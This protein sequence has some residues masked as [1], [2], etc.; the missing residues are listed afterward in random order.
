MS[1]EPAPEHAPLS[2]ITVEE[3]ESQN[4]R[5]NFEHQCLGKRNELIARFENEI[6]SILI[7][8]QSINAKNLAI[9]FNNSIDEFEQCM[10]DKIP[11]FAIPHVFDFLG[12]TMYAV[13]IFTTVGYVS[14]IGF[15]DI[16]A[17]HELY[18]AIY[19]PLFIVGQALCALSFYFIQRFIR[20]SIPH[21]IT[22]ICLQIFQTDDNDNPSTVEQQNDESSAI[23]ERLTPCIPDEAEDDY[24]DTISVFAQKNSL[25]L[26]PATSQSPN[27]NNN[28]NNV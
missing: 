15:G 24:S 12:S 14:L 6:E 8:N 3:N 25:T 9:L 13:T 4:Y 11:A 28:N 22:T 27:L 17:S 18:L 21:F 20:Y 10:R 16:I 5:S 7:N 26:L 23:H 19:L 1:E 2:L